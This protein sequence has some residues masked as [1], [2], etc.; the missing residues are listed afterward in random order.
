MKISLI[1]RKLPS[2]KISLIIEYYK[3]SEIS[4]EGKRKHLRDRENLKLY[5]HNSPNYA[6]ERK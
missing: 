3:G 2:G 5:L 6:T 4:P 1:E